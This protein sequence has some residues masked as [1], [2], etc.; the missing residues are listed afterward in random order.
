MKR[1]GEC[2]VT[3][4]REDGIGGIMDVPTPTTTEREA[5]VLGE[6]PDVFPAELPPGLPPKR[7]VD[8]KIE[9]EPDAKP[10]FRATYKMSYAELDEL[11]KQLSELIEKGY[12]RPSK[13]PYGAPIL[14]VKK[15]DGTMRMCIDYRALNKITTKNRYP[16]PRIDELMDRL[17]GAS[18][19][20]KIDLR[21]GYHQVRV[22]DDDIQKTA[23]RTRYGHYEFLVLPFGLTNAPATFMHLMHDVL[24]KFLD[25]FVVVYLDDILIY[26]ASEA[27]HE[28]HV[29]RVLEKLRQHQLYAKKSK[30]DFF[31][32]SVEF[33]GHVVTGDG[34]SME[35]AKIKAIQQWPPL[36]DVHDVRQFLGLASWYRR[37]IRDFAAISTP[38]S[39][40]QRKDVPW[41]WGPA[42]EEA[43]NAIKKALTTAPVL[44]IPN[45]EEEFYVHADASDYA[46]GA[47]LLQR[48]SKDLRPVAY[49]SKK[50]S[51]AERR[52]ATHDRELLA[53]VHALHAWRCYL[54]RRHFT[55]LSDHRA[56]RYL[57]T[58]PTLNDRQARW[59]SEMAD[60]SFDIQ[61]VAGKD[62]V[63]AD[64]LS[65][66]PDHRVSA[67]STWAPEPTFVA[68]FTEHYETEELEQHPAYFQEGEF[69]Y[70]E[71]DGA[72]RIVVPDN[73]DLKQRLL[74]EHH[75]AA[76]S[77][78]LG[79]E[80]TLESI[81][82]TYFWTG[83]R[84]SVKAYVDGCDM[85]QRT[86]PSNQR[87]AG[88][89][90][91]LPTPTRRWEQVTMDLI[92]QLPVTKDGHDA[93]IVFVDRLSKMA[94][95][96]PTTTTV[97]APEAAAIFFDT[98]FRHHGLPE[99]LISDRDSKFT[100][101]FWRTT[102]QALGTK[103]R[104]STA[105]HPQTDGQTERTNRTLEQ[106]LRA[107]V[108][109]NLDNWD[110]C[111]GPA[112]FAINNARQAST[113]ESPFYLNYGQHPAVPTTLPRVLTNPDDQPQVPATFEFLTKLNDGLTAAH[114]HL[115]EAQARQARYANTRR[116]DLVFDVGDLVMLSTANL[117]LD[118]GRK[119][120]H[121]FMGPYPITDIVSPVAYR[122]ALL[123][124]MSIHPVFHVHL[125]KPYRDN[126]EEQF[127]TRRPQQPP[128]PLITDEGDTHYIIDHIVDERHVSKGRGRN[129]KSTIEYRVRWQGYPSSDDT[130][131]TETTLAHTDQLKTWKN[132]H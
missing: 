29:R 129:R 1:P 30:C 46:T 106:I 58:Q 112:E 54:H 99:V 10:P 125:L 52:Y 62:N 47:V 100:S 121:K 56:L 53:I 79:V 2:F 48:D 57:H 27:E 117:P 75:D 73:A 18:V 28:D 72:R 127:P 86:K 88:L 111:L 16:L 33:L 132:S 90:Q 105:Y 23:F 43:F 69:W 85:C 130:W 67:L 49:E 68:M 11:K 39:E 41:S 31:K 115:Q 25:D 80:K 38:I 96:R 4:V 63:A 71:R 37:F 92:V 97:T 95:I 40:L 64:A 77:G 6:F 12:I 108:N 119:L 89:L 128:P 78:H 15:K 70:T 74:F 13:S 101:N 51:D 82:R 124:T 7:S 59:L 91:P 126:D 26:S 102:F 114:R 120:K 3:I 60:Y 66:R 93:I 61:H 35:A 19:F 87:P 81:S 14:F 110:R 55:I 118:P 76:I 65:R 9:V 17:H 84:A 24:R 131:E 83:L 5:R 122:L 116:R 45:V 34:I 104:F 94:L 98:V 21:S 123:S 50:L 32:A 20:S 107:Y 42:Q 113:G 22:E 36:K 44:M 109:R 103:L 8:H